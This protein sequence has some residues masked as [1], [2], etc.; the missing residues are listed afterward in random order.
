MFVERPLPL[1]LAPNRGGGSTIEAEKLFTQSDPA[2]SLSDRVLF[3]APDQGILLFVLLSC[4]LPLYDGIV[5][6]NTALVVFAFVSFAVKLCRPGDSAPVCGAWKV[7]TPVLAFAV[8][9]PSSVAP[10]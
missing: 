1:R 8:V 5:T 6:L 3:P 10:S 7:H 2:L 4:R 9:I